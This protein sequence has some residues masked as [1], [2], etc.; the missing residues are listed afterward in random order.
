MRRARPARLA[1]ATF[2]LAFAVSASASPTLA[3]PAPA[4]RRD[5]P[6][7]PAL[8][9]LAAQFARDLASARGSTYRRLLTSVDP[10]EARLRSDLRFSLQRVD[11]RGMP[12]YYAVDNVASA[13][14]ISTDD[15]QPGGSS[16]F[17]LDGSPT[18]AGRLGL[19]D[20]GAVRTTHEEFGGR[21]VQM[22]F[23]GSI[24]PHS[25]HVAGTL[26]AAGVDPAARG[27]S[28]AAPLQCWDYEGDLLE[29]PVAAAA[30][31]RLSNHSYS[32]AC[33]WA[34]SGGAW[35]WYGD[36][37]VSPIEDY[38][39]GFY[40]SDAAA[41][42]QIAYAAPGYLIVGSAGNNR[43]DTG[44][45]P[46]GLH[47]YWNGTAWVSG[48]ETRD[49]DGGDTGYDTIPWTKNAKNILAV[50]AV[51]DLPD[52][53]AGP[54]SVVMASFSSWGP[55]DDGRIKP[56]LCANGVALWSSLSWSDSA[57]DYYTGTSMS[58]PSVTGSLNLLVDQW[59]ATHGGL[60]RAA[61]LKALALQTASECGPADGPDYRFGWGLMN[62]LAA[63]QVIAADAADTDGRH[64][65][66]AD[67]TDGETQTYRF[68]LSAP[69]SVR[70]TIE[71]TDVPH[72]SMGLVVDNPTPALVNDLDLRLSDGSTIW[73]PWVLD[74]SRPDAPATTGDN[75]VDN[76]EQIVV[77]SLPAGSYTLTVSHKGTLAFAPQAYTLVGT[78][79]TANQGAPVAV[80][81][82]ASLDGPSWA[83]NPFSQTTQIA[84]R[85]PQAGSV[86]LGIYDV[87]GRR[88][89]TL[90]QN[91]RFGPGDHRVL[92]DGRTGDGRPAAAGVYFARLQAGTAS[93]VD[94][95][96]RVRAR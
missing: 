27:M 86:T 34:L 39:F 56:D 14:T 8:E 5:A 51:E 9:R 37:S 80:P 89:R 48:N 74:P 11:A 66:E 75:V 49:P 59:Q 81:S 94:T 96:V 7:V 60:P 71:W 33:G 21:A 43:A 64:V 53:Y 18:P 40:G 85:M 69:E 32:P 83:P 17:D 10:A 3:G 92:W 52:G 65:W 46:G 58:S 24:S 78:V 30:G 68:S 1:V 6:D 12:R 55:A 77:A 19:W 2:V 36:V 29:M 38:G 4:A 20:S 41:W 87:A 47:Y 50:G 70:F 79:A 84:F 26:I 22:D 54:E 13:G 28:P 82:V 16:G 61:T 72:Q 42:D 31:M 95:L 44:P 35:Y 23:P 91:V 93:R 57:H 62:T 15:V 73:Q 45:G 90:A 88:V 25:T 63:A 76:T 67:L